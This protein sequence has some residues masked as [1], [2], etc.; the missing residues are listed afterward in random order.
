[1]M[2]QR[3]SKTVFL[4]GDKDVPY[5]SVMEVIGTLNRA[6]V[7]QVALVTAPPTNLDQR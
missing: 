3:S 4:K 6:G 5:G 1:M 7:T 2:E